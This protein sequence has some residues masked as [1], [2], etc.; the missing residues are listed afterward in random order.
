[1]PSGLSWSGPPSSTASR[2]RTSTGCS[3]GSAPGPGPSSTSWTHPPGER[4]PVG[5]AQPG[6]VLAFDRTDGGGAQ[7]GDLVVGQGV[8]EGTE[9]EVVGQPA[10][11]GL[12]GG[13]PVHV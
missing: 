10:G 2:P 11:A 9:P 6:S 13:A 4:P 3:P 5:S 8:I 1:M 7:L 12:E